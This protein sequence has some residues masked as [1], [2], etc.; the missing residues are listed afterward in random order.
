MMLQ[1]SD[2]MINDN[3]E[4]YLHTSALIENLVYQER[5]DLII[6]TGDVVD[7]AVVYGRNDYA[8]YFS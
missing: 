1:L 8:R 4:D 3:A 5:P 2:L 7:P 6:L